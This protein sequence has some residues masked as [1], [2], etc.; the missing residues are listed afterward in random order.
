MREINIEEVLARCYAELLRELGQEARMQKVLRLFDTDERRL[1]S[2]KAANVIITD[3]GN[4]VKEYVD[5]ISEHYKN[6]EPMKPID[7]YG[8]RGHGCY[9]S[10]ILTP[11]PLPAPSRRWWCEGFLRGFVQW[12]RENLSPPWKRK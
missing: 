6:S 3:K 1:L 2:Q 10:S 4:G 9:R 8:P 7:V 12:L 5:R 11:D